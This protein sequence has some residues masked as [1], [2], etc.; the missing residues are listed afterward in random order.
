MYSTFRDF[1]LNKEIVNIIISEAEFFKYIDPDTFIFESMCYANNEYVYN[2]FYDRCI[3]NDNLYLPINSEF[4]LIVE[5]KN[6]YSNK[7]KSRLLL[8]TLKEINKNI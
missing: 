1:S 8:Y 6:S 5:T 4:I 3:Y 2:E 7:I